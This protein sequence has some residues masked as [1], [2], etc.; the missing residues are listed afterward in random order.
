M[1]LGDKAD[2]LSRAADSILLARNHAART[3]Q[4]PAPTTTLPSPAQPPSAPLSRHL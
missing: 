1:R 4:R 2:A 3:P